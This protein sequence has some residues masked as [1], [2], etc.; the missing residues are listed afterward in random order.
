M[1]KPFNDKFQSFIESYL[2]YTN[3]KF[4]FSFKE[5][6]ISLLFVSNM[7]CAQQIN[8]CYCYQQYDTHVVTRKRKRKEKKLTQHFI[9]SSLALSMMETVHL[10]KNE[11]N[12][13]ESDNSRLTINETYLYV[14][15]IQHSR[16][17]L[18]FK[19]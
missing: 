18:M 12:I 3:A 15:C 17:A 11:N 6:F 9:E 16:V 1:P 7:L 2:L 13:K 10:K 4:C 8:R 5:I 19:W 14:I